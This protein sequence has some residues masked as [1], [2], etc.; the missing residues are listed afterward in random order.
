VTTQELDAAASASNFAITNQT[1][2]D[3]YLLLLQS[4][5]AVIEAVDNTE[6]YIP[7]ELQPTETAGPRAYTKP[8]A[9]SNVLNAWSHRCLIKAKSPSSNLLQGRTIALKDNICVAGLPTTIGTFAQFLSKDGQYPISPVDATVV[10]RVLDAG[11]TITGTA[12]CENYS[13]CPLSYSAASGPVHN[14]W[15]RGYNAGGSSSGP[16][17]LVAAKVVTQATGKHLGETVD[18]AL[19]GDQGGSIRLPA[20]YCGIYGLKPTL[21]LVPYTG[22]ASIL[23]M[24][25][26]TGPMCTSVADTALLL[27][28]IAGYD[29]LDPRMTAESPLPSAVK[30]YPTLLSTS[31]TTNPSAPGTGLK[32]GI[33][34]ESFSVAGLSPSLSTQIHS[35]ATSLFTTSGATTTPISIPLHS[36]GAAIWTAAT[37]GSMALFALSGQ[38]PGYLTYHPPHLH[39]RFPVDQEWYDLLTSTNPAVPN[40]LLASNYLKSHYPNSI[41]AKAHRKALELRAAYDLAFE[42]VDVLITPTTP[43]VA[44]PLPK[45]SLTDPDGVGSSVMD[46]LTL[47]IGSTSNTCP[48]NITGHP[49][50]S[51]P[52]GFLAGDA[53]NGAET[54]NLPVG[55][56]IVAKRWD[57][58]MLLRVAGVWEVMLGREK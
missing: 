22:I 41:E 44:P 3:D 51:V 33:L 43:T 29:G 27:R 1:E 58:E 4:A 55:M 53:I 11:A 31:L 16:G 52:C 25:D 26:H 35:L 20:S 32:I 40:L 34:T 7:V 45:L 15:A 37:R 19:G 49:A 50:I 47:S 9:S 21:G 56:Q 42:S 6:D 8:D 5:D 28:V 23:P 14:P 38:M 24:I 2:R 17:A 48:F 39:P 13:A 54:P 57:E 10:K 46:K 12:T 18:M 30:D 36:L